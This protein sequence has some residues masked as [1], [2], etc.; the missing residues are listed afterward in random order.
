M[1]VLI[2]VND[3]LVDEPGL[4][5]GGKL[6]EDL[7]AEITLL[8]VISKNKTPGDR[9]Q[10]EQ[11]LNNAGRILGDFPADKKVRRGNVVKRIIKEAQRGNYDMVII[12]VSKIGEGRQPTSSIHRLLLKNLPCCLLVVKNPKAEI[13][14]ILICTG[15]LQLAESLIGVG[16]EIA[17]A[18]KSDATL[19]HVAANIPTMYTGLKSIEETLIE[20]LQTDTPVARHL[21]RGSKI[22]AEKNIQAELKLRHGSAVYEIVRETDRENYDLIV[23]GASR[24]D[25]I[26]KEWI[27]GNLTQDIVDAVG[28]PVMVVNQSRA[29][30][31]S[32]FIN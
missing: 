1:K 12:T 32:K 17:S 5:F 22:L 6:A 14:R 10:G 9:D 30:Q 15:G 24:A 28:I 4:V 18:S 3:L 2:C 21:R 23:I 16:A 8:H 11:L 26:I 20:L 31:K 29:A 13:T 19:F 25:T 27:Y 7:R